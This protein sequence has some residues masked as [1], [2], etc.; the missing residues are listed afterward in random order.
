MRWVMGLM[1]PHT[2]MHISMRRHGRLSMH[3]RRAVHAMPTWIPVASL[4]R[5]SARRRRVT[6]WILRRLRRARTGAVFLL[7]RPVLRQGADDGATNSAQEAVA[8]LVADIASCYCTTEG[9]EKATVSFAGLRPWGRV[10]RAGVW[11]G[12]AVLLNSR[13][14]LLRVLIVVVIRAILL[15]I[16]GGRPVD[17]IGI[18][19]IVIVVW[20]CHDE[21]QVH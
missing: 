21:S 14:E 10:G 13:I 15:L 5:R 6:D 19:A 2:R 20:S 12:L 9:P 11:G 3:H 18:V 16:G 1:H 8:G 17:G 4:N 7:A